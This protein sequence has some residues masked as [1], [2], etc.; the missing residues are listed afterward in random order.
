MIVLGLDIGGTS[1]KAALVR[2]DEHSADRGHEVLEVGRVEHREPPTPASL[3]RASAEIIAGLARR[4]RIDRLGLCVPGVVSSDGST[5]E[6]SMNLRSLEGLRIAEIGQPVLDAAVQRVIS[7]DAH[8]AGYAYWREHPGVG[9]LLAVSLGTGVGASVLDDGVAL[10]VSGASSGHLGQMDVGACDPGGDAVGPD[11]SVNTL[12]AF[13]GLPALRARFGEK[14]DAGGLTID[15]VPMRAL[16]RALRVAHAIYRPHRIALLGGVGTALGGV[17]AELR[18][19][20]DDGLTSL[21][22]TGW[23]LEVGSSI[24]LAAVGASLLAAMG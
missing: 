18:A 1:I 2:V 5:L 13:V 17:S 7:T 22:R 12:E 9:R 10:R 20:I 15:S 21:A 19:A 23:T 24:H 8:A 11:G 3:T 14:I 4:E 6:R 16:I